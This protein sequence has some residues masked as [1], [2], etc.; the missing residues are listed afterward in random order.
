MSN[1]ERLT[2]WSFPL[3]LDRTTYLPVVLS[4]PRG[5]VFDNP[6]RCIYDETADEM[7]LRFKVRLRKE[8]DR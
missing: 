3:A 6:P 4:I 1:V 2:H 5:Y 7:V 8:S